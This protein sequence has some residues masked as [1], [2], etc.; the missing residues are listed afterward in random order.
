MN[1]D[2]S[3]LFRML[4]DSFCEEA[5]ERLAEMNRLMVRLETALDDPS[6][7]PETRAQDLHTLYREFH[8]LKGAARTVELFDIQDLCQAAE[9][10]LSAIREQESRLTHATSGLI[11]ETLDYLKGRLFP[12]TETQ[13]AL[14]S[15]SVES[16][17]ARLTQ[18]TARRLDTTDSFQKP[19]PPSASDSS[20]QTPA[21]SH[22]A[23]TG[24]TDL[25][26]PTPDN[27]ASPGLPAGPASES[28]P[29]VE[30]VRIRWNRLESLDRVT[31][32]LV[33]AKT[34]YI[35]LD[36]KIRELT[37]DLRHHRRFKEQTGGHVQ[38]VRP[39]ESR[40]AN[41][42]TAA[43]PPEYEDSLPLFETRLRA[44]QEFSRQSLRDLNKMTTALQEE[45]KQVMLLPC[46]SLLGS[47]PRTARDLATQL[48]KKVA[49]EL[50][51]GD[52]AVDRRVL[53]TLRTPLLH[54]LRN[55][56]DHGIESPAERERA[57]KNRQG[58]IWVAVTQME[59]SQICISVRD[60]GK[61]IDWDAVRD[62]AIKHHLIQEEDRATLTHEDLTDLLFESDL[63]TAPLITD[64]SG[65]GLGMGIVRAAAESLGGN[66][67]V[68]SQPGQGTTFRIVVPTAVS[69][70]IGLVV[71]VG[72]RSFVIPRPNI[73]TA[74]LVNP[75]ET[76]TVGGNLALTIGNRP[77]PLVLLAD[78]L[79]LEASPA[80][81]APPSDFASQR[82]PVL[83]LSAGGR[84]AAFL[85]DAL[86]RQLD[87]VLKSM[88][89]QLQRVRN[90]AGLA[91][92]GSGELV[93]VLHPAD[94]VR[95]ALE[96]KGSVHRQRLIE[97]STRK[98]VLVVED[99][100]TSR[101]LLRNI[102]KASGFTVHTAVDGEEALKFLRE[103]PVDA[104]VSDVEMPR[105]DGFVLTE[106]L[107]ATERFCELP[108]LLVTSLDKE[109]QRR[110]GLEAGAD[111]YIVKSS[112]DQTN[113][114]EI[115]RKLI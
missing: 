112:F 74:R 26:A 32:E 4:W 76:R 115:L 90:V 98:S 104:V 42:E 89:P 17:V 94:L 64:I 40:L 62:K 11:L 38:P 77:T 109:E 75:A 82:R 27:S 49:V 53:E 107:R 97:P 106:R 80:A 79:E 54:L 8:S 57:G 18:M 3:K 13:T 31:Q 87:I 70:F 73:E 72:A 25:P 14:P 20:P 99:S 65:R 6:Q 91:M 101:T 95:S 30:T 85:V 29:S 83:I 111:A 50:T 60:D 55:C 43:L 114:I 23:G 71:Q 66:V 41:R 84:Q 113:L 59:R 9:S 69:S 110:R 45:L 56:L 7:A 78:V 61:G 102:L 5:R 16:L 52:V 88:G 96:L 44:M 36:E 1:G 46:A 37:E 51:G 100:L 12:E 19:Q 10:L 58:C 15:R 103:T 105:M 34:A 35:H 47:I 63:S 33:S 39:F 86:G 21:L 28:A 93:P 68:L 48:G 67:T 81:T 22:P 2:T 24:P 108:I 92:L